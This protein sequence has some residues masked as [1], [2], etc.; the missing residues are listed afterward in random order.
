MFSKQAFVLFFRVAFEVGHRMNYE[1]LHACRWA[2]R[3][4]QHFGTSLDV[5]GLLRAR[6]FQ[7]AWI[8]PL[9]DTVDIECSWFSP[10]LNNMSAFGCIWQ[11]T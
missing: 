2:R 3:F 7:N 11:H 4:E 10:Q 6:D 8:H 9:K 1:D 5:C